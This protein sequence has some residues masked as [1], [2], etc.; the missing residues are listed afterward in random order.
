MLVYGGSL[1]LE[2]NLENDVNYIK[3]CLEYP[4]RFKLTI[5]KEKVHSITNSFCNIDNLFAYKNKK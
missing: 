5:D 2:G 1:L 4:D 3:M